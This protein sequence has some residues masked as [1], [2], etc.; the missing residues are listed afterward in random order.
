MA[1]H[2]TRHSDAY[3]YACRLAVAWAWRDVAFQVIR[4]RHDWQARW[5]VVAVTEKTS[6]AVTKHRRLALTS[7]RLD[8]TP[9]R[10][11]NQGAGCVRYVHY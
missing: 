2:W 1:T 6:G 4:D 7:A 5:I 9:W 8:D 10:D 3:A 11:G